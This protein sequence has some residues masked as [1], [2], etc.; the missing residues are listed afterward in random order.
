MTI[1]L[2]HR[3]G[4]HG[5]RAIS[6]IQRRVLIVNAYF[7]DLRRSHGRF[8]SVPKS[9]GPIYLAGAFAS[10]YCEIKLYNEQTS[11]ALE[12]PRLFAWPDMLVLTGLTVAFDRFRQ[13]TAYAKTKN[14]KVIVVV[15][16]PAVR[17]MPNFSK[18]LFDYACTG[19]VEELGEVIRDA[20]GPAYVSSNKFPRFDLAT[21][22]GP[23]GYLES[24]RNCNFRCSFCSLTGEGNKYKKYEL[25]HIRKQILALGKRRIVI[26]LDNNFYGNDREFFLERL[27]LIR[28]LWRSGYFK[29]W[30]ALVTQDFFLTSENLKLVREAGCLGLFSGVESFDSLTLMGFNKRQNMRIPQVELIRNCIDEG[31]VLLYGIILDLGSRTVRECREQIEL[32]IN[33]SEITLPAFITQAIP[34]LGTPYFDECLEQRRLL[35]DTRL[36]DMDGSTLVTRPLD[37]I[38]D[39]VS[40]LRDLPQLIG[41]RLRAGRHAAGFIRR[42][43]RTLNVEQ[44]VMALGSAA[45]VINPMLRPAASHKT[46]KSRTFVTG[47][48][49]LD[50]LYRPAFRVDSRYAA[51]FTPTMVTDRDGCLHADMLA[52]LGKIPKNDGLERL[53]MT[54]NTEL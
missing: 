30:T 13:L 35:P 12:D 6:R 16:G 14:S 51:Y 44:L 19:D 10:E 46:G 28:G 7:D 45:M 2:G 8:Y 50:R 32:I 42:Y 53:R 26:F 9:L 31:L 11:G 22:F 49:P 33:H 3:S 23:I 38:A 27:D 17:A 4:Q 1:Y 40:F 25:D 15:G 36:R 18:S 48:E 43:G 24:S 29:G 47:T 5:T 39:A 41:F 34:L 20:W 52:D 21:W 54:S 37:P